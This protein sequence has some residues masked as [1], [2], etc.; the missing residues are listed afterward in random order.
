MGFQRRWA[1]WQVVGQGP[2]KRWTE[3]AKRSFAPYIAVRQS[4]SQS[5]HQSRLKSRDCIPPKG[6]AKESAL[7]FLY[8]LA[9]LRQ[10]TSSLPFGE[11]ARIQDTHARVL[12]PSCS[13]LDSFLNFN[14]FTTF[15]TLSFFA[16]AIRQSLQKAERRKTKNTTQKSPFAALVTYIL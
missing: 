2:T 11:K 12:T 3:K 16:E 5:P 1:L 4:I 8:R 6:E 7:F 15:T 13:F 14:V 10:S 9:A